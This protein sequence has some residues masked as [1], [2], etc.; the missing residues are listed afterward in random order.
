MTL[1]GG[2]VAVGEG[3]GAV[4][5]AGEVGTGVLPILVGGTVAVLVGAVV[6]VAVLVGGMVAVAV[7]VWVGEAVWDGIMVVVGVR[8]GVRVGVEVEDAVG[9]GLPPPAV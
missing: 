5:V 9:V 4:P 2:V 3:A 6:E 8:V 7:L 1:P